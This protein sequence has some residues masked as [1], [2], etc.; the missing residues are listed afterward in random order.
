[1]RRLGVA[2]AARVVPIIAGLASH[3]PTTSHCRGC[4]PEPGCSALVTSHWS[5][6]SN[7]LRLG[8]LLGA[9]GVEPLNAGGRAAPDENTDP[10]VRAKEQAEDAAIARQRLEWMHEQ[11][12]HEKIA[13][14]ATSCVGSCA[15]FHK[16]HLELIDEAKTIQKANDKKKHGKKAADQDDGYTMSDSVRSLRVHRQPLEDAALRR[17][18]L[19]DL[20]DGVGARRTRKVA[21]S[22]WRS[23]RTTSTTTTPRARRGTACSTSG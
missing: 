10:A 8:G 23:R 9:G 11:K 1:M 19:L 17:L 18:H 7:A 2:R 20:P 5:R 14:D 4:P 13:P 6:P 3:M 15:A 12:E 22:T 21:S 16:L